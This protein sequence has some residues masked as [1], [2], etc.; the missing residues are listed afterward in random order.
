MVPASLQLDDNSVL[1]TGGF[2]VDPKSA[3]IYTPGTNT[4]SSVTGM[5]QARALHTSTKLLDGRILVA[6]GYDGSKSLNTIEIY[7]P[8]SNTWTAPS[9]SKVLNTARAM[10]TAT[11]LS[12]LWRY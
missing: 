10:H 4:W 2:G 7:T 12:E 9:A 1:V 6:G 5:A 8:S 11:V 3:E